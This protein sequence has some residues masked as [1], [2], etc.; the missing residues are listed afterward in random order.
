MNA[1]SSK[2]A[3]VASLRYGLRRLRRGW[4]S[5]ELLIL[6]LALAIAVAAAASVG[7]FTERVRA[8]IAQ[9]TGDALGADL[10]IAGRNPLPDAFRAQLGAIGVRLADVVEFPSAALGEQDTALVSVKAVSPDYP[11]RGTLKLAD[12]PYGASRAATQGPGPGEVWVDQRLW[13]ALSLRRGASLQLGDRSFT[14]AALIELEPDRGGGFTDLAPRA[15]FA[16]DELPATGL[17]TVGSRSQFSTLVAGTPEQLE[18]VRALELP[19]ST[20]LLGPED[21]RPELRSALSRAGQFLDIAVL[22]VT[23]LA[24]AAIALSARQHGERL[25]DEAALLRCLGAS[26]RFLGWA[27]SFSVLSLG[28]LAG[29]IGLLAGLGAQALIASLLQQL[30]GV[31]LPSASLTPAVWSW[32]LGLVLL[33]GFALPPVLVVRRTPPLRVFQRQVEA[34]G[35]VWIGVLAVVTVA[36]L[37]WWRTGETRMAVYV[38]VGAAG[39]CAVLAGLATL[40]VRALNPLRRAGGTALRFG[41]GNIARR[42]WSSVGQVVALGIAL[43]ALLLV[44][45]V[46]SDLLASWQKR[47]PADT[48]NQFLINIQNEQVEPL[49]AF[50]AERGYAQLQIWPMARGRLVGLNGETVTADSFEDPETRRWINREFNLSWTDT[51]GADNTLLEG[52]WWTEADRGQP[53][54][55]VD[56]YVVERLHVKIGDTLRLQIADREIDLRVHNIRRVDW[57]SFKPNFFLVTPPGVLDDVPAQWLTSVYLKPG[58]RTLLR[59]LIAQFPN[60]T[61]FDIESAMNQVRGVMDRIA[62]AVEFILLFTLAA[63]LM[64]VLAAIEGTRS[65]RARETALLRVLGA[66]TRTIVGGLVAEYAVLGLIAGLVAA[67]AAQVLAWVLAEQVFD[68]RYGPRPLL[69][70][71]GAL[72]GALLVALLGSWSLRRTLVRAPGQVLRTLS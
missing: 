7:I 71:A 26:S 47:L 3:F 67:C 35:S 54:L 62:R 69:W 70:L 72:G 12:E 10:L 8:A 48:P 9:Q 20:R 37:L 33:M 45:F 46:R 24:A 29:G 43:L 14:V 61:V 27:L 21:A 28:L 40:L 11:L 16:L 44:S 15:L 32:A 56:D 34:G 17:V 55:S 42:R 13:Q 53:W 65:E 57:E 23:L 58:D 38:L 50:F 4:R 52:Q 41:L 1:S 68:L 22:A 31:S 6:G 30:I 60:V 59:E 64:V 18:A 39:A 25:R 2:G 49:R 19:P 5:G 63:G 51:F 36:V 66:R